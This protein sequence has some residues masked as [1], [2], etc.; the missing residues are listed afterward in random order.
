[1][2]NQIG[3]TDSFDRMISALKYSIDQDLT[4]HK[5]NCTL[6]EHTTPFSTSHQRPLHKAPRPPR[7]MSGVTRQS[8]RH[9]ICNKKKYNSP[10]TTQFSLLCSLYFLLFFVSSTRNLPVRHR[11]SYLQTRALVHFRREHSA[12]RAYLMMRIGRFE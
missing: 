6:E 1:M 2:L 4:G 3:K 11:R 7:S 10:K 8:T 5:V 12:Q 9:I